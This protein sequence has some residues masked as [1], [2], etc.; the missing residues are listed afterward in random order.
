MPAALVECIPN[1]SEARRPEVVEQIVAAVRGVRGVHILDRHSDLDHNRTVLT[2]VGPPE[3]VEEA[4]FQAIKTAAGLINLDE[5][6]GEHP[7]LGA[8]DVVPFVPISGISMAECV[9]MARRLGERVGFELEIPVYLYE[10]AATRPE[11]QNLENI[12]RG[13]YEGLKEEMGKNPARDPDFGP[14]RVGPA[15]GTVIGARQPLIAYN[16]YLTTADDSIAKKIAKTV[17]HSSGGL[18]Y[19]KGL[20]LLVEGQAQVSMNLTNFHGTPLPQ[21]VEM[22]RR[23]AQR[24]GV[25]IDH[26]ELVGLIPQQALVEAARW[27]LQLDQ[28]EPGQIL[29]TRLAES[30]QESAPEAAREVFLEALASDTPTP[31]GGAAA[32]YTS[33][34]GAALAAMVA[35]LTI[36][37]KKYAEVDEMM[38]SLLMKAEGLRSKLA[39]AVDR[40]MQAFN[41]VMAAFK[42]PK[43]SP[44]E[45]QARSR[46][47]EEATLGAAHVPLEVAVYSLEVMELALQA[48]RLGN[49]NAIS[50]G[51]SAATFAHAGLK[52]AAYNVRINISS[53]QDADAGRSLIDQVH[54]LES[55]A[56]ALEDQVREVLYN[57]GGLLR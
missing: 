18:R 40:D 30:A 45:Q 3:A 53:L 8:T 26:S 42:L 17:R 44:E 22:I 14:S 36:G 21:V 24:Y 43:S 16:V 39:A 51:A 9:E 55:R 25:G 50:D 13:Q 57:R 1:F 32:A 5:H 7:R 54:A 46:A 52:S 35:R 27:Y 28:F 41:E 4:A 6:Q 2:F 47:I 12:R 19:V 23:E 38:Q 20:G 29:E 33:A 56:N 48:V 37:R 10:E 11:R 34:Q 15:G 31:G 49:T